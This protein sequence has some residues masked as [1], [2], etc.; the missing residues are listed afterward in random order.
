MSSFDFPFDV[1][2]SARWQ[3]TKHCASVSWITECI[4][5]H[6]TSGRHSGALPGGSNRSDHL[7]GDEENSSSH[8]VKGVQP[9]LVGSTLAWGSYF[10][11]Y[12]SA[13]SVIS[14]S[15]ADPSQ[16][17]GFQDH[18]GAA[19]LAGSCPLLFTYVLT[20]V[21]QPLEH[22]CSPTQCGSSRHECV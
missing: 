13:K 12:D 1:H 10:Y 6:H 17:L 5:Q 14:A 3:R 4:S 11:C 9:A 18:M 21:S 2:R 20:P 8:A 16:Q 22:A 7:T 15:K 19:A